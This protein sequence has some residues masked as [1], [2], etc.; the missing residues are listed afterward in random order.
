MTKPEEVFDTSGQRYRLGKE[1]GRGGQGAV[2]AVEGERL[3]VKL[4]S[5][6][7]GANAE[8]LR[9]QLAMVGRFPI[10]DLPIARPVARIDTP[11]VGYVMELFTGMQSIQSLL[12]PP[13]DTESVL[14]WYI[15]S[16]GSSRRLRLL[17]RLATTLSQ[18]HGKGLIY[19]DL[20]PANVFV[21]E[22]TSNLE[23]RLID[24][25]NLRTAS[26]PGRTYYTPGYGAPELVNNKG[27]PSSLSDAYAFA[28]LAFEVL[29]LQHPFK[30][31]HVVYGEPE[32]EEQALRG[33]IPW[34]DHTEKNLN[35]ASDGIPRELLLTKDLKAD[36][37]EAFQAGLSDPQERPGVQRWA[38]HLHQAADRTLTCLSCKGSYY[39]NRGECPWCGDSR[40]GFVIV[41][42]HL[43]DPKRLKFDE[44]GELLTKSG[45]VRDPAGKPRLLELQVVPER[46]SAT[47]TRRVTR[48]GLSEEGTLRVEHTSHDAIAL[49]PLHEGWILR[50]G[51]G[52]KRKMS[53][54]RPTKVSIQP[55]AQITLHTGTED[56]QHRV[57]FLDFKGVKHR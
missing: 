57:V 27:T 37:E 18:L 2:F 50:I 29:S 39:F 31:D 49:T 6:A 41:A 46:G 55:D 35:R 11:Y 14:Q 20:S 42:V 56:E 45:V 4:L 28:V 53:Q 38:E 22:S 7:R 25:D 10:K 3:A 26:T 51:D 9:D 43:W 52:K 44:N 8:R 23:T 15:N 47:L 40:P 30:G 16:G 17:T 1:L 5:R 24:T 48:G 32:L 12:R 34:I 36:F 54:G 19:V 21:S 13:K 33:Q